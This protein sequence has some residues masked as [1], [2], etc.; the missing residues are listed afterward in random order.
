MIHDLV[1]KS[2]IFAAIVVLTGGG[3]MVSGGSVSTGENTEAIGVTP[4]EPIVPQQTIQD[5]I[6]N[7]TNG[8]I[9]TLPAGTFNENIIINKSITLQ[10]Y[11][12]YSTT[13][14]GD[15]TTDVVK[16]TAPGVTIRNL[17]VHGCGYTGSIYHGIKVESADNI[18][19][20][21]FVA[22]CH[23]NIFI[24]GS[25]N[26][27]RDSLI[28]TT[29]DYCEGVTVGGSNN[30]IYRNQIIRANTTTKVG[31]AVII[32]SAVNSDI[33]QNTIVNHEYGIY[34][35]AGQN[36]KIYSNSIENNDT[37]IFAFIAQNNEIYSNTITDGE[38]GIYLQTSSE[39]NIYANTIKDNQKGVYLC[40][41]SNSNVFHR[42][43]FM[44]NAF[45][46]AFIDNTYA[47]NDNMWYHSSTCVGNYWDDN[48][49]CVDN[50]KGC[51]QDIN[52]SDGI[53][54]S[55]Y[56]NIGGTGDVDSYPLV[57]QWQLVCG[58]A[59][60]DPQGNITISDISYLIG[61]LTQGGAAPIPMCSGDA[62]GDG[63]VDSDDIDYLIAY[64]FQ[65]GPAPASNCCS[66]I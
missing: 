50:Y 20:S 40:N 4:I 60:G 55:S 1:K 26:I 58:N 31:M 42:N 65:G 64:L 66:C 18:I 59:N 37:G 28:C 12:M 27:V 39:N 29:W 62:D 7:A 9:I 43:N 57:A 41:Y 34:K 30:K 5:L 11:H 19:E 15:C 35:F 51:N 47:C 52:G 10:G 54:D 25:G 38:Y 17:G 23:R 45:Y 56:D 46:H 36:N 63:D 16:I 24:S 22:E 44:H 21:T 3:F 8:D 6:D 32:L 33:Y 14:Q 53:C 48:T 2:L 13:I 61:Y 49:N